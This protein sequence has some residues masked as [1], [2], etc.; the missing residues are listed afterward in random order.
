M[1]LKRILFK[2][3]L[4]QQATT[5]LIRRSQVRFIIFYLLLLSYV[6]LGQY[7]FKKDPFKKFCANRLQRSLFQFLHSKSH[8]S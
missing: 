3:F 2:N 1:F 8:K 7:V 4:R 6:G 5:S